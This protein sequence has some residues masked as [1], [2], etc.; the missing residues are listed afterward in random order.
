MTVA[1]FRCLHPKWPKVALEFFYSE[2]GLPNE[3]DPKLAEEGEEFLKGVSIDVGP[4]TP[5]S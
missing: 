5:A 4:G 1:G 3:L 2:R